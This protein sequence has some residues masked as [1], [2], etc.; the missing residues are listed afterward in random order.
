MKSIIT[1][2]VILC[3]GIGLGCLAAL[4]MQDAEAKT[5]HALSS[6][7]V[8]VKSIPLTQLAG[9]ASVK[10][11]E[12]V[13]SYPP[14]RLPEMPARP[15]SVAL[16]S[17]KPA[18]K[19]AV[20]NKLVDYVLA[21][22]PNPDQTSSMLYQTF[23][24]HVANGGKWILLNFY[25]E[26]GQKQSL[27]AVCGNGVVKSTLISGARRCE[28]VQHFLESWNHP[29][30]PFHD[31]LGIFPITGKKADKRSKKYKCPMP[32]S[33]FY[34][35]GEGQAI[36]ACQVKDAKKLGNPNSSGC[37]RAHYLF[38]PWLYGWV[39]DVPRDLVYVVTVNMPLSALE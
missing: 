9:S 20:G 6:A 31:H 34:L 37:D 32:Y 18:S 15:V 7:S 28:G 24:N 38:A 5:V 23:L 21:G 16:A 39:G 22:N 25:A 30:Y 17:P 12:I 2:L 1:T 11:R 29:D 35:N 26:N 27:D 33:I 4:Y 36:H 10:V 19:T 8:A 3:V 13:R 14:K